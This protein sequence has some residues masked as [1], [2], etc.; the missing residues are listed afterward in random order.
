MDTSEK[1]P[2]T[3]VHFAELIVSPDDVEVSLG[4]CAKY[5]CNQPCA[6]CF[7]ICE[8]LLSCGIR[9]SLL[10]CVIH[11]LRLLSTLNHPAD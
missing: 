8:Q 6:E 3:P 2:F 4:V 10:K 11:I 1:E 5:N 9:W 7:D